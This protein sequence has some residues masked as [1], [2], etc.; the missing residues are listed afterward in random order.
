MLWKFNGIIH[1]VYFAACKRAIQ[2]LLLIFNY[3]W[4][5]KSKKLRQSYKKLTKGDKLSILLGIRHKTIL[6]KCAFILCGHWFIINYSL[7]LWGLFN[8]T[9]TIIKCVGLSDFRYVPT[10][11]QI[12]FV[13]WNK[14]PGMGLGVLS[15]QDFS[16]LFS[17]FPIFFPL[18]TLWIPFS[19]SILL[20]FLGFYK[21]TWFLQN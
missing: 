17:S 5:W 13:A 11:S 4:N 19:H 7:C 12:I 10:D 2:Y 18:G 14:N 15:Q 3:F 20:P 6:L 1:E 16:F 21:T 9:E 8:Q